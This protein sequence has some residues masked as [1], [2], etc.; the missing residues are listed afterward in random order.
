M[1]FCSVGLSFPFFCVFKENCWKV[2]IAALG[3]LDTRF[4]G[5]EGESWG[6]VR[7]I[8]HGKSAKM[9]CSAEFS[10]RVLQFHSE[11]FDAKKIFFANLVH[12]F[13]NMSWTDVLNMKSNKILRTLKFWERILRK[14]KLTLFNLIPSKLSKCSRNFELQLILPSS[15][16]SS[17]HNFFWDFNRIKSLKILKETLVTKLSKFC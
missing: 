7:L 4:F 13:K 11:K 6:F 9:I 3:A 10:R 2:F 8:S 14:F 1:S 16:F 17:R 15:E 5:R 12:K